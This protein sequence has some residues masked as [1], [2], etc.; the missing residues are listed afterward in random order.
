[1]AQRYVLAVLEGQS[2]GLVVVFGELHRSL[3]A[4]GQQCPVGQERVLLPRRHVDAITETILLQSKQ[5]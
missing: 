2:L 5:R 3:T 1:M 4:L